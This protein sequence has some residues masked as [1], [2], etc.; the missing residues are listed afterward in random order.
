MVIIL[1]AVFFLE[2]IDKY[3]KKVLRKSSQHRRNSLTGQRG[4]KQ[5]KIKENFCS[6]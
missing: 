1:Y 2:V 3:K 4:E 6:K 5:V